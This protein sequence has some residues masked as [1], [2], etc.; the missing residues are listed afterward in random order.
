MTTT[1]EVLGGGVALVLARFPDG[2]PPAGQSNDRKTR[3]PLWISVA[4]GPAFWP[5]MATTDWSEAVAVALGCDN[6][7]QAVERLRAP[8][9]VAT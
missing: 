7:A 4:G 6:A 8:K 9:A 2:Q 5:V 3:A 1:I